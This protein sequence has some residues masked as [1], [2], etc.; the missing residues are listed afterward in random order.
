[1]SRTY[2]GRNESLRYVTFVSSKTYNELS[3]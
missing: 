2:V 3:Y 1:V